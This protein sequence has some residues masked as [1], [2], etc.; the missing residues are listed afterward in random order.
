MTTAEIS[1]L[2]WSSRY[3]GSDS[4]GVPDNSI[5]DTWSRVAR[6]IASVESN[7]R[8]WE[9]RFESILDGFRFLPGGRIL[10]GAGLGKDVTL[11][12]CFVAGQLVDSL[13]GILESLK[14]T[15]LTMQHGGG[16]GVDFSP[17]RPAGSPAIRTGATASG[18]VSF[19][20]VW[21]SVCETLLATGRRRGAMMGTLRCDHPDIET[22]IDAKRDI[23]ALHNFNLS[24]LVTDEF[25]RAVDEDREWPLVYPRGSDPLIEKRVSARKLWRRIVE[26]AFE[27]AEP[28]L[29]FV[30]TINRENN[31]WYCETISATN[32]CGE[33]P[34][35]AYGA[36]DLGS[37]NLA[38]AV[39]S[40]FSAAAAIDHEYLQRL[41]GIAVRFLDNV[42]DVSRYPLEKQAE[43]A[44]RTRRIGLGITGLGDALAMLG[45]RYDSAGARDVACETIRTIRDA[46]YHASI[47]LAQ[48]KGAFPAFDARRYCEGPF[49]RRLPGDC[50]QALAKHGIRNSHILSIAPAC[51]ISLL[52]GNVSSGIEPIFAL[53]AVRSVRDST[54]SIR[55]IVVEDYAFRQW[56]EKSAAATAPPGSFVTADALSGDAHLAMQASLQPYVDSAIS[57]T[58]TLS[59]VATA[60]RVDDIFRSAH[61]HGIK[62]CTVFRPGSMRGEVIRT[63]D[64]SHCC[65]VEREC[66]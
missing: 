12:N 47:E 37:I 1:E 7:S 2:I 29:L 25:L 40:P 27:S 46:A 26:A 10:A 38:A 36:C 51:T 43:Q 44:K 32:P 5:A 35:P 20:H 6:S 8:E 58:I 30:D 49:I 16:I 39:S 22:F 53:E 15:A 31:L 56:R 52:A 9:R 50:R 17:L 55:E 66:D 3:R 64:E 34:L 11:F 18:P 48:E 54:N 41:C 45:L 21:D 63:R 33:V 14:E 23:G 42:I 62:G 59:S 24:V 57:K 19:M 4:E 60:D 28:G 65:S 61:A 13:D